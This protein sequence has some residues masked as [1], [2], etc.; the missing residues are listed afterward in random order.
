MNLDEKIDEA[1]A[2]VPPD[3][4]LLIHGLSG[5]HGISLHVV[6]VAAYF[7]TVFFFEKNAFSAKGQNLSLA[8]ALKE[9]GFGGA[10]GVS[11]KRGCGGGLVRLGDAMWGGALL[12]VDEGVAGVAKRGSGDIFHIEIG[13]REKLVVIRHGGT[14]RIKTC[15]NGQKGA[16]QKTIKRRLLW[17]QRPRTK[18]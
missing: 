6:H 13:R 9:G 1:R 4:R 11:I 16:G 15:K 10:R 12:G 8:L 5:G 7:I 18:E 3:F 2:H 14:P 17:R